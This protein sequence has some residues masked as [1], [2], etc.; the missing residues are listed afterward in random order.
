[1]TGIKGEKEE[2]EEKVPGR[3]ERVWKDSKARRKRRIEETE[4]KPGRLK[5]QEQGQ[6][7]WTELAPRNGSGQHLHHLLLSTQ[8]PS[9]WL[10]TCAST[11]RL[12]PTSLT[13]PSPHRPQG[14][15][16]CCP[17]A[18]RGHGTLR[19]W[20][21]PPL[22]GCLLREV[23]P[24]HSGSSGFTEQNGDRPSE[25]GCDPNFPA[26]YTSYR[27]PRV[28]CGHGE[29]Q[30]PRGHTASLCLP[31]TADEHLGLLCCCHC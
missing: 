31:R 5:S 28:L 18:S 29:G 10:R 7:Q 22:R 13:P 24:S 12:T 25:K 8:H 19:A 17:Y 15:S 2:E 4:S 27:F 3:E 30:F 21:T 6:V 9:T 20:Q 11:L 23:S 26:L 14:P 1:M 16:A